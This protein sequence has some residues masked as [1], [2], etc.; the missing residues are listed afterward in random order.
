MIED[1][2]SPAVWCPHVTVATVVADGE[3][4][5][6]VEEEI[7]GELRYNQPAGHLEP[8]ESLVQAALRETLE[9]TGWDVEL[10]HLIGVH[11]WWSPTHGEHI[12]R[13]SF[14]ARALRHHPEQPLDAGIRRA[15]WLSRADIAAL[16]EHLRSP[17]VLLSIDDWLAGQRLPLSALRSLLPAPTARAMP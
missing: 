14:A 5:L 1:P 2:A 13:F 4:F 11:Q 15:L 6:M 12:V 10:Q 17:L 7:R 8:D 16:G 3:R 9:E